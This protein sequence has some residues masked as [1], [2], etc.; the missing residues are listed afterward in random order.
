M[1]NVT[2]QETN[3]A[4]CGL[5]MAAHNNQELSCLLVVL[6][7]QHT[8]PMAGHLVHH[9]IE[10]YGRDIP[11]T[12]VDINIDIEM[13]VTRLVCGI[14]PKTL[15]D[16]ED[17]VDLGRRTCYPL[18]FSYSTLDKKGNNLDFESKAFHAGIG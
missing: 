17:A 12:K 2:F 8:L 15:K 16:L 14:K 11:L 5:N 13:P 9:L 3:E 7:P 4:P 18:S 10:K 6:A 1:E